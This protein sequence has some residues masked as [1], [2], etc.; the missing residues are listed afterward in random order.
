MP[1]PFSQQER[2]ALRQRLMEQGLERFRRHGL[3]GLRID[4]LCRDVGIAKGSFYAFFDNKEAL[5]FALAE[6]RDAMHKEQILAELAATQGGPEVVLGVFFDSMLARLETDPLV[7]IVRDSA[8]FAYLMRHA[9][10][11][12]MTNNLKG[13][14]AFLQKV[15][16][17]LEQRFGL[18]HADAQTLE[19]ASTLLMT[20][21]LQEDYLKHAEAYALTVRVLREMFIKRLIEG[22]IHD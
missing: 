12:Y 3:R 9:P 8:E 15:A 17:D 10:P 14:R 1:R 7:R 20:L 2:E 21:S 4:E 19:G 18:A 22:P 13:D 11:D 16:G 5:Y 6:Q